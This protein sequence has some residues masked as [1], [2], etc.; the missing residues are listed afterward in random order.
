[1]NKTFIRYVA[2]ADCK[3]RFGG[4]NLFDIRRAQLKKLARSLDVKTVDDNG[5]EL[6]KN[7]ILHGLIHRLDQL[8]AP[9]EITDLK[10]QEQPAKKKAKK[11]AAKK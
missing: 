4:T 11:K 10:S 8:Q 5:L 3:Y 1:M 6:P 7:D 9:D 2:P